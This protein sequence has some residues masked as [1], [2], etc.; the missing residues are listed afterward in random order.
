[1][2]AHQ[3]AAHDQPTGGSHTPR[4]GTTRRASHRN[5]TRSAP[6]PRPGSVTR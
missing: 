5:R 4:R 6:P 1:M 2:P 3:P